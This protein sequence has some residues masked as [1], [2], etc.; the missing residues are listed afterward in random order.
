MNS[1]AVAPLVITQDNCQA[2]IGLEPRRFLALIHERQIQHTKLGKLRLVRAD[3]L[4]AALDA[5]STT[6][7][8]EQSEALVQPTQTSRLARA[9]GLA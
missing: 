7:A 3:V 6:S 9:A 5:V 2:A 1:A 8:S 4:L